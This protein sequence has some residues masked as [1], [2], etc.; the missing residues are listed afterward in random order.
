MTALLPGRTDVD[1]VLLDVGGVL[2]LPHPAPMRAALEAAGLSCD[3]TPEQWTRAHYAGM[4]A[5][6]ERSTVTEDWNHYVDAF[7]AVVGGSDVARMKPVLEETFLIPSYQ[8]WIHAIADSLEAGRRFN[9]AGIPVAVVSNADG[10]IARSL[11]EG[12][13]AQVGP[14]PG[15]E[16]VALVDSTVVGV[17]KPDPDIFR[18]AL[19]PLGMDPHRCV[20]VGDSVRND[21][22]GAIAAGLIPLLIDP[23]DHH[24]HTDHLRIGSLL[25]LADAL[26]A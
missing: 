2:F 12:G 23:F 5:F 20:Y 4:A 7:L 11:Q 9:R 13:V 8:L 19:E 21:V 22:G 10:H 17:A 18:H 16:L 26:G 24:A 15:I 25:E 14:G 6:D 1:A 3:A